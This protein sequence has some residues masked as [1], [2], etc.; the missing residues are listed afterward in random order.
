MSVN[1]ASRAFCN[2]GVQLSDRA[3]PCASHRTHVARCA[4][5]CVAF[6]A[7]AVEDRLPAGFGVA[8]L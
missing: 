8:V 4:E 1:S 5:G 2:I 3:K 7:L 6:V